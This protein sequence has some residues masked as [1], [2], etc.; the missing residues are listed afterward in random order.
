M[1]YA[2]LALPLLALTAC[3]PAPEGEPVT[4]TRIDGNAPAPSPSATETASGTTQVESACRSI[5]FEDTPLTHCLATP[6]RHRISMDLSPSGEVP[7]RS[8]SAYSQAHS[9]GTIA[10][11]MNAGMYDDEG[12]PIGY[13]VEDGDRLQTLSTS[14]GEGNFH[15]KPN[16]VFFGSGDA[17][18]VRT[19]DDFLANV[20]ERPQFGTQSGPMLVIDGKLHPEIAQDGDSR[21]VR[22]GVGVD[23]R[24]RAHFVIS[25]APISFGKLAR[26]YRDELEVKNALYLDGN[27]SALWNPAT[28]R[29]DTG[30]PIGPIVVVEKKEQ[31]DD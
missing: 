29:L 1:K 8:L 13:Y 26:F 6:A 20:R 10:F 17:W 24:G 11:A 2:F 7:Y 14:D 23:E 28:G 21:L 9:A 31:S 4:R 22:N 19:T 30:A 25:N 18:E 3:E 12:K 27:V 5:I 15:M 16:G